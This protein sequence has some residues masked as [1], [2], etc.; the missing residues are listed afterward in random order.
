MKYI[1][2]TSDIHLDF[3]ID[4]FNTGK[5]TPEEKSAG[6]MSFLWLPNEMPEDF[7]TALVLA[8]DLWTDRKFL[9]RK[10]PTGESW[11][12]KVSKRFKYII[13]VLGNHD[14]W[15]TNMSHEPKKI[16]AELEAQNLNNVY[17]LEN[18]VLVLD[19]VKFVG[20]TL[21]TD[22]NNHDI[23]LMMDADKLMNDY[24]KIRFG[25]NSYKKVTSSNLYNTHIVSRNFIFQNA[26]KDNLEQKIVVVTHMPPSSKS[27]EKKYLDNPKPINYL[28]YSNMEEKI[29]E[30]EIDIWMHGHTHSYANYNIGKTQVL[31]NPRGYVGSFSPGFDPYF[32]IKV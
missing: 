22:Y 28:Y 1:R 11:L 25:L 16:K 15:S 30:S 7:E 12:S 14:Y 10:Y 29:E 17:L 19:N 2:L 32:R 5:R 13:F 18:N 6:E 23:E 26:I 21:W 9:S 20:S 24:K 4:L 8:G 3:D 31:A 27:V